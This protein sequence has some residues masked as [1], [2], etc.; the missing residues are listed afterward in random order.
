MHSRSA[1]FG[2]ILAFAAS[3]ASPLRSQSWEPIREPPF[4]RYLVTDTVTGRHAPIDFRHLPDNP[5]VR[6]VESPDKLREAA[7]SG[8]NFSGHYAITY[9][10]C[11]A[12]NCATLAIIDLRTGHVYI[13]PFFISSHIHY[14]HDSRL[15]LV[16]PYLSW[17]TPEDLAGDS[18]IVLFQTWYVWTGDSLALLDSVPLR[19]ARR[20]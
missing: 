18:T 17:H 8:P 11:L 7:D 14:R 4:T 16:D 9:W 1:S 19:P 2:A 15:L 10:N 12:T 5:R 6:T 3:V 13:A 20:R